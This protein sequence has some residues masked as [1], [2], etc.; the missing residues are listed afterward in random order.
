MSSFR[1]SVVYK[2]FYDDCILKARINLLF[3][4]KKIL[5]RDWSVGRHLNSFLAVYVVLLGTKQK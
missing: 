4:I 2:M 5:Y 1:M 3:L